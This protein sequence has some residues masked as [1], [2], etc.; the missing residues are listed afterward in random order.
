VTKIIGDAQVELSRAK[1]WARAAYATPVFIS[2]ADIYWTYAPERAVRPEV[3]YAQAAHE[4]GY[5]RFGGVLSPAWRNPCGLKTRTAFGDKPE[6][7]QKFPTW[8]VGVIAHLDHLALYAGVIGY[9]LMDTPDPRH[10]VFILG[11]S[12]TVEGLGGTWA[13]SETYGDSIVRKLL[14]MQRTA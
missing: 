7:H 1:R 13:P 3:A 9:P 14:A 6:D 11:K 2:L 8:T 4:T 12:E 10:S 5:G